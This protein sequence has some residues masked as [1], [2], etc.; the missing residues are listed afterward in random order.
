[1]IPENPAISLRARVAAASIP[2][3]LRWDTSGRALLISD[4]PRRAP[5][6]IRLHATHAVQGEDEGDDGEGTLLSFQE[7]RKKQR[8]ASWGEAAMAGFDMPDQL[9]KNFI[10]GLMDKMRGLA[11]TCFVDHKLLYIDLPPEEYRRF[12]MGIFLTPGLWRI[13]G[14]WVL[15]C[16]SMQ[17]RLSGILSRDAALC[18][19]PVEVPLL[20]RAMLSC[21]RGEAAVTGFV[22]TL[23]AL[24]AAGLRNKKTCTV[25][26][27]A[28]LCAHYLY[29]QMGVGLPERAK[30]S[31][32]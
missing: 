10:E 22:N 26:A 27:C 18:S 23:A 8:K 29:T 13:P 17:S 28:A 9:C 2:G 7:K 1:M 16:L 5:C 32:S 14:P 4:A 25:Y 11:A 31:Y 21:T 20:R 12:A 15:S 3:F 24:D 30:A 19:G 6:D